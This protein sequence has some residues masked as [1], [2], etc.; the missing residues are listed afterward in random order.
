MQIDSVRELRAHSLHNSHLDLDLGN[1]QLQQRQHID[2]ARF[3]LEYADPHDVKRSPNKP[4]SFSAIST[5]RNA[6]GA[7][8][9]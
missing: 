8:L 4:L 6:F 5:S 9:P 2:G 3:V 7:A 1:L